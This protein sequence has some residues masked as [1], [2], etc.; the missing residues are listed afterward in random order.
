MHRQQRVAQPA[1]HQRPHLH[2][3]GLAH[4]H[5]DMPEGLE[6][7]FTTQPQELLALAAQ[8][9]EQL[10]TGP[11]RVLE[12]P[13]TGHRQQRYIHFS[14]PCPPIVLLVAKAP[15]QAVPAHAL[16]GEAYRLVFRPTLET[17]PGYLP[18]TL[19]HQLRAPSQRRHFQWPIDT[20]DLGTEQ[21]HTGDLPRLQ[22]AATQCCRQCR[23]PQRMAH[24]VRRLARL[25]AHEG[26]DQRQVITG[27]GS[28]TVV[29]PGK[30]ARRQAMASHFRD[31]DIETGARKV[32]AQANPFG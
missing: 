22:E 24:P 9:L 8:L 28:N 31:P 1:L 4:Q 15:E 5:V 27:V 11:H 3:R 2:L 17:W 26:V 23:P 13:C 25:L 16:Q 32:G 7:F 21:R 19:E 6:T 29:L 10:A 12:V 14:Q 20:A 30:V 18:P